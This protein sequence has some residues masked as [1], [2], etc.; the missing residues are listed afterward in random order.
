[1]AKV[2]DIKKGLG[3]KKKPI[4]TTEKGEEIVDKVHSSKTPERKAKKRGRKKVNV[5]ETVRYTIDIPESIY[6]AIRHKVVDEGGT[7]KAFIMKM[8]KKELNIK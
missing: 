4:I 1:M 7:M 3:L 5:E 2:K 6:K 8:L